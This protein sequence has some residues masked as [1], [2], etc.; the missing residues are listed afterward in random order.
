MDAPRKLVIVTQ[1][2]PPVGGSG[3][4]RAGKLAQY[5]PASN[6]QPHILTAAFPRYPLLDESLLDDLAP[7]TPVHR[8]AGSDPASIAG[9]IARLGR[10][11]LPGA[12]DWQKLDDRLYWRLSRWVGHA[13]LHEAEQLW[14]RAASRA[15]IHLVREHQIEAII[16]TSPPHSVQRV[17]AAVARAVGI[18]WIADLRDPITD[19]FAYAPRAAAEHRHWLRLERAVVENA[20]RVVVTCDD[21]AERLLDR[22]PGLSPGRIATI[23]NGHDPA[24]APV[25]RRADDGRFRLAYVGRF[26]REQSI[27]PILEA[28]RRLRRARLDAAT[29]ELHLVGAISAGDRRHLSPADA[30]FLRERGYLPHRAA[31][32]ELADADALLW[33]TPRNVGGRLCIPGKTFEYL[34][35][36]GPIIAWTQRGTHAE[37]LLAEA[38]GVAL[39]R[40]E[41]PDELAT[42]IAEQFDRW[43]TTDSAA[44]TSATNPS[45]AAE[46]HDPAIV[47]A[48]DVSDHAWP[49]LAARY[50]D[51]IS[52]C[53]AERRAPAPIATPHLAAGLA[54]RIP[55]APARTDHLES[56]A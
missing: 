23:T 13:R 46:R 24:D 7:T 1:Q 45:S 22:W 40:G 36:G 47:P 50:A 39:V 33:L 53:A 16:T 6:W 12:I 41:N 44:A 26:Y 31:L 48:R 2:F 54:R 20:T 35:F 9:R 18:P 19:H 3:V 28:I 32:A 17:G 8:V 37:R 5:L 11:V 30:E 34:A 15:A 25:R 51:L 43:R 4:Q 38:S 14:V 56:V 27:R 29:I 21:L 10:R 55:S 42:A 49:N 52:T